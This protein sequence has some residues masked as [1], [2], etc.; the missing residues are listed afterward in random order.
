VHVAN[1]AAF[2]EVRG[3]AGESCL[4]VS[5]RVPDDP[6]GLLWVEDHAE[7]AWSESERAVLTVAADILGPRLRETGGSAPTTP[8]PVSRYAERLEDAA[9][10]TGK[11]AHAFDNV[12]TGIVGFSEL[13]LTQVPAHSAPHQYVGEVLRAAQQGVQFTQQLHLFSRCAAPGAGPT[14]LRIVVDDEETRLAQTLGPTVKVQFAVPPDLPAVAIDAEHVRQ[15]LVLL[16]DNAIESLGKTPG[17]VHVAARRVE[18]GARTGWIGNPETGACIEIAIADTGIG[19]SAETRPRLFVEP[20]FTTKPRHRGLGLAIV[21][22]ILYTHRGGIRLEPGATGGTLARV[23]LP[24][25]VAG[26]VRPTARN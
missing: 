22:R 1:G 15:L 5:L 25:A 20:F 12:L 14:S 19:V 9:L 16:I 8:A 24:E 11:V 10:M 17:T 2:V 26:P 3:S 6:N 4:V 7:R 18:P 13:T 21:C 23:L